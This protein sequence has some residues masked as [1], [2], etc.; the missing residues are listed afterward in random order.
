MINKKSFT[1][2]LLAVSFSV[3]ADVLYTSDNDIY[4]LNLD[5]NNELEAQIHDYINNMSHACGFEPLD[6]EYWR[7]GTFSIPNRSQAFKNACQSMKEDTIEFTCYP[8]G[9]LLNAYNRPSGIP[10]FYPVISEEMARE[11]THFSGFVKCYFNKEFEANNMP[12]ELYVKYTL[13]KVTQFNK[14]PD[15]RDRSKSVKIIQSAKLIPN[16]QEMR[17][18]REIIIID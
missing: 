7:S 10:S 6:N 11:G 18:R 13:D 9:L 16:I 4:N 8:H 14:M 12:T 15:P 2:L 17:N 5:K 3:N 1:L